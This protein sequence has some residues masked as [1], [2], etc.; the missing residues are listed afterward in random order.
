M[1]PETKED[2]GTTVP[3][4][5]DLAGDNQADAK[6]VPS[7]EVLMPGDPLLPLGRL[8]R[9]GGWSYVWLRKN[10]SQLIRLT[11]DQEER[12]LQIVNETEDSLKPV[13][14]G[15]IPI[16]DD[17]QAGI[18]R[19]SIDITK[20]C[21]V[22]SIQQTLKGNGEWL[23]AEDLA[24]PYLGFKCAEFTEWRM[25]TQESFDVCEAAKESDNIRQEEMGQLWKKKKSKDGFMIDLDHML[26][27]VEE[28]GEGD[29]N[30][31]ESNGSN[32]VEPKNSS[33]M[34]FEGDGTLDSEVSR[35]KVS[36]GGEETRH[37]F[38]SE[39]VV[40]DEEK[41]WDTQ[42]PVDYSVKARMAVK[43][44][45]KESIKEG[46]S[47]WDKH[48]LTHTG[49]FDGCSVC[50]VS[51]KRLAP[52]QKGS[53]T[54]H[55]SKKIEGR[56][57]F[58]IDWAQPKVVASN[59]QRYMAVVGHVNSGAVFCRGFK[60]KQGASVTAL[61]SARMALG[62][63]NE[64]FVVHSDNERILSGSEM[65]KYLRME[66]HKPFT[67]GDAMLGVPFRSNT[68]ARAE[69]FVKTAIEGVRSLVYQAGIPESWWP[70]AAEN[71]SVESARQA[72]FSP[73]YSEAECVPFGTLGRAVVPEGVTFKDKFT[74][75]SQ[76]VAY[77]GIAPGTSS[78]VRVLYADA[79]GALRKGVIMDRDV[80][81]NKG[82]FALEKHRK[83]LTESARLFEGFGS[84]NGIERH[85]AACD[86]C[87]KWRFVSEDL[88]K[89]LDKVEFD[90]TK[91][92]LTC[93]TE[94]DVRVWNSYKDN[95]FKSPSGEL[96]FCDEEEGEVK[97]LQAKVEYSEDE[98][99]RAKR[100]KETLESDDPVVKALKTE[101]LGEEN[102]ADLEQFGHYAEA[103]LKLGTRTV[104]EQEVV[105]LQK[106]A[107]SEA[108]ASKEESVVV[109]QMA[110]SC[111]DALDDRNPDKPGWLE[112]IEDEKVSLFFKTG[113][114]R[115]INPRDLRKG[116]EVLPSL[117]VLTLKP[118]GR[119]KARIVACGNFQQ[120]QPQDVY[121]G[122]VSHEAW[123]QNV[124]MALRLSHSVVQI[125]ISTA[126]LQTDEE[127][128]D[129]TR[130]RT[131]LRPPKQM[132]V[133]KEEEGCLWEVTKSIYGLRSA[134]ASWKRTLVRWL[135][136]T[137]GFKACPYDDNI[138]IRGDEVKVMLYVD[139]L[140]FL[141]PKG[142]VYKTVGA[143]KK[144]FMC[145]DEVDLAN[146]TKEKPLR[147]LGHLL[148]VDEDGLHISQ[149]DHARELLIRFGMEGCNPLK[150]LKEEEFEKSYLDEGVPL[151]PGEQSIVRAIIGGLQYIA[152]GSRPDLSTATGKLAEGQ[153]KATDRHMEGCKK[154]LRYLE[155]SKHRHLVLPIKMLRNGGEVELKCE[156]DASYGKSY[157]RSG[158]TIFLDQAIC[159]WASRRQ[160]CITLS[161]AEAELVASSWAAKELVG[162]RNFLESIW[163]RS[164]PHG[165]TFVMKLWGDNQAAN[166]IASR[167]SS[168]RR[169][170]HL[171]LSYLFVR[172]LFTKE[173][174]LMEYVPSGVNTADALTK[175]LERV[176]LERILPK[177]C[178][179]I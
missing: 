154:V 157:A 122:V 168:V 177:M 73:R 124:L 3:L 34:L 178:L 67:G 125:D 16:L 2:A 36:F 56:Q 5:V 162:T 167:Q 108:K 62:L 172:D 123:I 29:S 155:G 6:K 137:E 171:C 54:D 85:Q 169:V 103:L 143:L 118:C 80:H 39:E 76:Y 173:S 138:Y 91:V 179:T 99:V 22:K 41:E 37:F 64:A 35:P 86:L 174:I 109:Y 1:R 145:T 28:G 40:V 27:H 74:S 90:C 15:D 161:T 97:T 150:A 31:V 68:N 48:C 14:E 82:T 133:P 131:I 117:L 151:S 96:I 77:L 120:V 71:F 115:L 43:V 102:K 98:R 94:E 107:T 129:P 146:A 55:L 44:N 78:G 72:G 50:E 58:T 52:K 144:R 149:E 176:K 60:V 59:G 114:L 23:S 46:L 75:R 12:I 51:K 25:S 139:D 19:E 84:L 57:M 119:K 13:I 61:H 152:G 140:I 79:A 104:D 17:Q 21:V 165:I 111:K 24:I 9:L 128:D 49:R 81:W 164:S 92:G 106:L 10:G 175:L 11:N 18:L 105:K 47:E 127:D 87:N 141:G 159:Y 20:G 32:Q 42:V 158:L 95:E 170:R 33:T 93:K 126:F 100:V 116:D 113:V 163:G 166:L 101:V 83:G 69:A 26:Q 89:S 70:I 66:H 7:G 38:S 156:F 112:G 53:S 134:P 121:C 63:E 88:F 65:E 142:K 136:E 130:K 132:P 4:R 160:R 135:V 147:F 30:Q 153:A 8:V 110:V 45:K 148:W